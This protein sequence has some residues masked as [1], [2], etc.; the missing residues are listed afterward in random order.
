MYRGGAGGGSSPAR[1]P[2]I[3]ILHAR[4]KRSSKAHIN[5]GMRIFLGPLELV[6]VSCGTVETLP[7]AAQKD[8]TR[9]ISLPGRKLLEDC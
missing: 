6:N 2:F 8:L 9:I 3:R 7:V 1:V 5:K 4:L